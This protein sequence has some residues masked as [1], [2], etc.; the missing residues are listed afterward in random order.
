MSDANVLQPVLII[1]GGASSM[2]ATAIER[3][4]PLLHAVLAGFEGT[5]ISGGTN[6]GAPGC[7]G[8]V[9][10]ELAR[11][12][13]KKFVLLGYLPARMPHGISTHQGYDKNIAI[14]DD[15]SP[16]QIIRY[17]RDVLDAGVSPEK[18]LMLGFGGGA[19]SALEYRIALGLGASVGIIDGLGGAAEELLKD[20]LWANAP[21]LYLLP[22]DPATIRAFIV[23]STHAF[24]AAVKEEIAKS[25]RAQYVSSSTSRL[26]DNMKSWDGLKEA[27]G[28]SKT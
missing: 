3:M 2:D 24:D 14:G 17:W 15:F 11:Q 4:H 27:A 16:D 6:A 12:N 10:Q 13:K 21:N 19:L 5:V 20:P 28:D 8:D 23:P 9:A 18:V 26:S 25:F 22:L 1:A 7:V